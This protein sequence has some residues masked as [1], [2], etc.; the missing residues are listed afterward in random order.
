[1]LHNVAQ[2]VRKLIIKILIII[3]LYNAHKMKHTDICVDHMNE[4]VVMDALG[5]CYLGFSYKYTNNAKHKPMY[6]CIIYEYNRVHMFVCRYEYFVVIKL[7][8]ICGISYWT[9]QLYTIDLRLWKKMIIQHKLCIKTLRSLRW[10]S[11]LRNSVSNSHWSMCNVRRSLRPPHW[12][13]KNNTNG[14]YCLE[15][16]VSNP[17]SF[18]FCSFSY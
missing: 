15:L 13:L 11:Q 14:Y 6:I 4:C 16:H 1:M 12:V 5:G 10:A 18:N 17:K 7:A 2:V 9:A 3:T 8:T